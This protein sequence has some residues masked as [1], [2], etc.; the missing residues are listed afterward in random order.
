[1]LKVV[2]PIILS[3]ALSACT[4][5]T[6]HEPYQKELEPEDRT[7]YVGP[8][9][10]LQ[11]QKDQMY[12]MNKELADKCRDGKLDLAVA[13]SQGDERKIEKQQEIIERTCT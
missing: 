4:A 9:G 2:S 1:M 8:E 7:E 11:S 5:T 12:L 10:L 6:N 13:Q 3:F